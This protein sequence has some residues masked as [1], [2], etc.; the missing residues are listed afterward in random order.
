LVKSV[1]RTRRFGKRSRSPASQPRRV[2][3]ASDV[4]QDRVAESEVEAA[5]RAQLLIRHVRVVT[6]TVDAE[7]VLPDPTGE[8]DRN[9]TLTDDRQPSPV[10]GRGLERTGRSGK[11]ELRP[12]EERS[13]KR[14]IC[15]LPPN[16]HGGEDARSGPH[17]RSASAERKLLLWISGSGAPPAVTGWCWL[18]YVSPAAA[19]AARK[20]AAPRYRPGSGPWTVWWR[21]VTGP[22]QESSKS[23]ETRIAAMEKALK[24]AT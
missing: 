21:P 13:R 10:L 8:P 17:D 5:D 18:E 7:P 12:T 22:A 1:K 19:A 4:R 23:P 20:I 15:P 9:R 11:T 2:P 16:G 14:T 24:K 3:P 6:P